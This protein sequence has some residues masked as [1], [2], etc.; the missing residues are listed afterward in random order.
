MQARVQ[1][2]AERAL[3]RAYLDAVYR[4][5]DD[6]DAIRFA[7][8]DSFPDRPVENKVH[9]LLTACN[10]GSMRLPD[11]INDAR[12]HLLERRV[13]ASGI[14]WRP[15]MS[16]SIDGLWREPSLW[17]T[18]ISLSVLDAL[19][20]EFEQNACVVVDGSGLIA[21]RVYRDDWR[22]LMP[23]DRRLQWRERGTA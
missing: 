21:L 1:T 6:D 14:A 23:T 12:M 18:D 3:L 15:G 11:A 7:I 20:T 17:L 19:A 22:S 8:G 10:P 13:E 4:I 9:A 2:T 16:E 5:G